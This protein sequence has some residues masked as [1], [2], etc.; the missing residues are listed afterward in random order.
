VF[1]IGG[2]TPTA[3]P[4][5]LI[6][7]KAVPAGGTVNLTWA[8]ATEI[9]NDHFEV[10]RSKDGKTFE[11]IG[12]VNGAGNSKVRKEYS[13]T[14]RDMQKG[15]VYYR[16]RQVDMNGEF[17]IFPVQVVK[18]NTAAIKSVAPNPFRDRFELQYDL[19]SNSSVTIEIFKMSGEKVYTETV[20]G[21]TGTNVYRY[22]NGA[23]LAAGTY[24]LYLV[25]DG[26][27]ISTKI[28][29]S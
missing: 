15:V 27:R 1:S 7:F 17:E 16:L 29:K 8:T 23:N 5:S 3:L 21:N 20:S 19:A 25:A 12:V 22:N 9:N 28:V 10:E 11:K 2:T 4:V 14:D 6:Y 18:M 13:Y 24:I 26:Q